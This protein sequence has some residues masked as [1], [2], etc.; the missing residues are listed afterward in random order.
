MLNKAGIEPP[1]FTGPKLLRCIVTI[2]KEIPEPVTVPQNTQKD[3]NNLENN[4]NKINA[5][6]AESFENKL[7]SNGPGGEKKP[8]V[9]TKVRTKNLKSSKKPANAKVVLEL[10]FNTTFGQRKNVSGT[11]NKGKSAKVLVRDSKKPATQKT[12]P[13]NISENSSLEIISVR[14]QT[15]VPVGTGNDNISVLP[16]FAEP[17]NGRNTV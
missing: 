7:S 12:E 4:I 8:M 16:L 13:L 10:A 6:E 3:F 11:T 5:I 9:K 1:P 14:E 17:T 15:A 2:Q